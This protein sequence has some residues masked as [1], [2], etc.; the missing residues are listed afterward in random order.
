MRFFLR[1]PTLKA[2]QSL[3]EPRLIETLHVAIRLDPQGKEFLA[4]QLERDIEAKSRGWSPVP[5]TLFQLLEFDRLL[6][7]KPESDLV[8]EVLFTHQERVDL[9]LYVT[10]YYARAR[11][12][13]DFL[14]AR[15]YNALLASM[16]ELSTLIRLPL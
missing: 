11:D 9:A 2:A 15:A 4:A 16:L 8:R 13:E 6:K 5:Y 1:K 7:R 14:K 12:I 10:R 3:T